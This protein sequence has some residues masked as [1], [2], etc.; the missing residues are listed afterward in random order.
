MQAGNLLEI[1]SLLQETGFDTLELPSSFK[2][3]NWPNWLSV[4]AD[5]D[6]GELGDRKY[7]RVKTNGVGFMINEASFRKQDRGEGFYCFV[8]RDGSFGFGWSFVFYHIG[9][10]IGY[11]TYDSASQKPEERL[12]ALLFFAQNKEEITNI[13]KA[14]LLETKSENNLTAGTFKE[15]LLSSRAD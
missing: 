7:Q 10:E 2:I 4:N 3:A 15:V 6:L 1:R 9:L 14:K 11:H 8:N 5:L 12:T 13:I